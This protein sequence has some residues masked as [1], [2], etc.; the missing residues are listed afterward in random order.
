MTEDEELRLQKELDKFIL[1]L[2]TKLAVFI[3]MEKSGF[4]ND[5]HNDLFRMFR[6]W[7]FDIRRK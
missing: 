2:K 3:S 5:S 4:N 6:Y 1:D 7:L